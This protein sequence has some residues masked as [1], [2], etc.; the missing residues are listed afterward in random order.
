M[1]ALT[2]IIA[3][4]NIS[5]S[6]RNPQKSILSYNFVKWLPYALAIIIFGIYLT[7]LYLPYIATWISLFFLSSI[8]YIQPHYSNYLIKE[9]TLF[10]DWSSRNTILSLF[11]LTILTIVITTIAV[12]P[13]A[14]D[15]F[16]VGIVT[17]G[18]DFPWL[19][20]LKFDPLF[21][22]NE[23]SKT[24]I[25]I[26]VMRIFHTYEPLAVTVS[27][28]FNINHLTTYYIIFPAISCLV[29]ISIF[30]CLYKE[31][32]FSNFAT[33]LALFILILL[34][35]FWGDAHRTFGNFSFV[36]FFQ[37]KSILIHI[38]VPTMVG[39][40][41][42][43][44]Y[45]QEPRYII[46]LF[47]VTI[48]STGT[49]INALLITPI[50]ILLVFAGIITTTPDKI[51]YKK[52]TLVIMGIIFYPL[53]LAS[54]I[55]INPNGELIKHFGPID[56]L[57][58]FQKT[59]KVLGTTIGN[60]SLNIKSS[61]I[62]SL[63]ACSSFLLPPGIKTKMIGGTI[64]VYILLLFFPGHPLQLLLAKH[65]SMNFVWRLIWAVPLPFFVASSLASLLSRSPNKHAIIF[66]LLVLIIFTITGTST[67][68]KSNGT[69]IAFQ[70]HKLNAIDY[71]DAVAI[72]KL[73]SPEKLLLAPEKL[74]VALN[75]LRKSP[76]ILLVRSMYSVRLPPLKKRDYLSLLR[77]TEHQVSSDKAMD[78]IRKLN[79]YGV[80]TII[81]KRPQG[82]EKDF[83][84]QLSKSD[85]Q[86]TLKYRN[87]YT[88]CVK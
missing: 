45:N 25:Y 76:P 57:S 67:L 3:G 10:Y 51:N 7:Q 75:C 87:I 42:L 78:T 66:S 28:I 26:P 15:A 55:K 9:K 71:T 70:N 85:F 36:R 81:L 74:S 82:I 32:L 88:I 47:F 12:R 80:K 43:Y 77:A 34:L 79:L 18:L 29:F 4:K 6:S 17:Q 50:T 46:L 23:L 37:G 33:I 20:I 69:R 61:I 30:F 35:I 58:Q 5:F 54:L 73:I 53:I 59:S 27:S 63:F 62:L 65:A 21:G 41:I 31:F 24:E 8:F 84:K 40:L 14:D 11:L 52:N 19:P 86:C 1:T 44:C 64:L 56:F 38:F 83:L 2:M 39:L 48:G 13:D 68:S 60:N 72:N 49:S 22:V 16:Y